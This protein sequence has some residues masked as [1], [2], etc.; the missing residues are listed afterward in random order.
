[1]DLETRGELG[2]LGEM[3]QGPAT[4]AASPFPFPFLLRSLLSLPSH[5]HSWADALSTIRLPHVKYICPH[6]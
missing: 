3:G 6:A 5:R 1:M 2:F 4:K